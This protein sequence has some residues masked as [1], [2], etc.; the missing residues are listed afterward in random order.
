MRPQILI[1]VRTPS[2][3]L[4]LFSGAPKTG[5]TYTSS[6]IFNGLKITGFLGEAG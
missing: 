3:V 6:G 1:A 4:H 2:E 5:E